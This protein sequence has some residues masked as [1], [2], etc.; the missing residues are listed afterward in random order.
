MFVSDNGRDI[1]KKKRRD[2]FY[3]GFVLSLVKEAKQLGINLDE[4]ISMIKKADN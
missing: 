4:L 1:I 2:N 3:E